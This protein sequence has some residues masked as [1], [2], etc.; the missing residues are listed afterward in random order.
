MHV[1]LDAQDDL[2]EKYLNKTPVQ[3]Y[4]SNAVYAAMIENVDT[5]FSGPIEYRI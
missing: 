1:Q 4:P 5:I 2:I 3:G